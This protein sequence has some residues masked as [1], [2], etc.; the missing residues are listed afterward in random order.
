LFSE[1]LKN[2][3]NKLRFL[4]KNSINKRPHQAKKQFKS[5][6]VDKSSPRRALNTPQKRKAGLPNNRRSIVYPAKQYILFQDHPSCPS[7]PSTPEKLKVDTADNI[8]D[9]S[10]P[11][12]N[13]GILAVSNPHQ[14][15]KKNRFMSIERSPRSLLRHNFEESYLER[16]FNGKFYG[17]TDE[18]YDGYLRDCIEQYWSAM[19]AIRQINANGRPRVPTVRCKRNFKSKDSC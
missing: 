1:R 8:Y 15:D 13:R 12:V 2:L 6:R 10:S 17:S 4:E 18:Q 3:E 9:T 14:N 11:L 7:T 5:A 19:G 16:I